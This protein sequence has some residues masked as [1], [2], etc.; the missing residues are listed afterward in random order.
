MPV[1]CVPITSDEQEIIAV[2]QVIN[3]KGVFGRAATNKAKLNQLD[4][5]ILEYF[6][7]ILKIVLTRVLG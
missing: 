3:D 7:T 1:L 2:L 5:E 4:N 6:K